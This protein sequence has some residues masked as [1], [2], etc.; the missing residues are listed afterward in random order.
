MQEE[1]RLSITDWRYVILCDN[2]T[3]HKA[4]QVRNYL[5]SS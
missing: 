4:K 5:E 3:I 2:A 1:I